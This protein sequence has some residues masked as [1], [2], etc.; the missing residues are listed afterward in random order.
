MTV[1]PELV[2]ALDQWTCAECKR[3]TQVND[4]DLCATCAMQI[5][6]A[7]L[8]DL[9]LVTN[10][11]ATATANRHGRHLA[12]LSGRQDHDPERAYHRDAYFALWRWTE[13]RSAQRHDLADLIAAGFRS[14]PVPA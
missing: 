10:A 11:E 4:V 7:L 8:V 14:A 1:N 5:G 2:P 6:L 13:S 12:A 3:W 9:V